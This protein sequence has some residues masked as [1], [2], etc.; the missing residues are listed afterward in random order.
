[1]KSLEIQ[2]IDENVN[3]TSLNKKK[4]RNFK[5]N[6]RGKIGRKSEYVRLLSGKQMLLSE[7]RTQFLNVMITK[8]KL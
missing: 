3:V 7:V 4:T 2:I 6:V 8:L 1:M 5:K